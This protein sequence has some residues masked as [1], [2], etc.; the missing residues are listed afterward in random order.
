MAV[1]TAEQDTR[2][3]TA[4]E[5]DE[6]RYLRRVRRSSVVIIAV[7]LLAAAVVGGRW[8]YSAH[9]RSQVEVVVGEQPMSCSPADDG[10]PGMTPGGKALV[11]ADMSCEL[12]FQ[13][14][15]HGRTTVHVDQ[16]TLPLFGPGSANAVQAGT[17]EPG[18][19]RMRPNDP[20]TLGGPPSDAVFPIDRD[21]P[22]GEA[23]DFRVSI[24]HHPSGCAVAGGWMSF[25]R[26]PWVTVES[27]GLRS[28]RRGAGPEL[29]FLSQT[30]LNEC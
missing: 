30:D 18:A 17:I 12:A 14:V 4:P 1:T 27:L 9:A 23:V 19:S 7:V 16:I 5:V 24:V 22:A 3:E 28:V 10:S 2:G 26:V 11:R 13:V 25:E 20:A 29:T 8:A 21:V 15:N 6:E